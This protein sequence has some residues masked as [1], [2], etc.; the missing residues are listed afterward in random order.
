MKEF[1]RGFAPERPV[2]ALEVEAP[3]TTPIESEARVHYENLIAFHPDG[4]YILAGHSAGGYIALETVRLLIRD[5][6][7][8]AFL[9]LFDT[10]PPGP[11]EQAAPMERVRLHLVNLSVRRPT[12]ALDSLIQSAKRR[13]LRAFAY[14]PGRRRLVSVLA[15]AGA[16]QWAG[17]LVVQNYSPEPFPGDVTLFVAGERPWYIRWD[18]MERWRRYLLGRTEIVPI[19]GDHLSSIRQPLASDLGRKVESLLP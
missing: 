6:K 16:E 2:Y 8:V 18:P 10:F 3:F 11:R 17:R 7:R 1:A 19:E 4:P 12:E 13:L 14:L 15:R 9:G 5:G